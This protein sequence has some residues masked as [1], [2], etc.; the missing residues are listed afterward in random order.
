MKK[1]INRASKGKN[2][3]FCSISSSNSTNSTSLV[4]NRSNTIQKKSTVI[5]LADDGEPD[6]SLLNVA[7]YSTDTVRQYGEGTIRRVLRDTGLRVR[8]H[9]SGASGSGMNDATR[10]DIAALVVALQ[11][12]AVARRADVAPTA[13]GA[14]SSNGGLRHNAEQEAKAAEDKKKKKAQADAKKA[15]DWKDKNQGGGRGGRGGA[16]GRVK[17]R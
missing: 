3:T 13:G 9:H 12:D 5:Q 15:Q 2:K 17:G 7:N 16:G 6:R 14:S 11:A 4:D 10:Q 1:H 8:G